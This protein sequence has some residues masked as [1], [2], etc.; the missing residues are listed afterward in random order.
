[1]KEIDYGPISKIL[2]AFSIAC[3]VLVIV[4]L[5]VLS[6]ENTDDDIN[7]VL[8]DIHLSDLPRQD[9]LSFNH[10][11]DEGEPTLGARYPNGPPA[12]IETDIVSLDLVELTGGGRSPINIIYDVTYIDDVGEE[13]AIRLKSPNIHYFQEDGLSPKLVY[14]ISTV[15][16]IERSPHIWLNKDNFDDLMDDVD[17][18]NLANESGK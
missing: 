17:I 10:V 15:R 16:N 7:K 14:N 9:N 6:N 4:S 3:V 12:I 11:F 18:E 2:L 13:R 1:M 5:F 8:S